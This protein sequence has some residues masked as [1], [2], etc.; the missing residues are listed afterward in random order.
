MLG[1]EGHLAVEVRRVGKVDA[2]VV[3]GGTGAPIVVLAWFSQ[4]CRF[5]PPF[6]RKLTA[7]GTVYA[8]SL[9][10]FGHTA[11]PV[12]FDTTYDLVNF[13]L[14]FVDTLPH[15][16]V[17]LVGLSFGGWLALELATKNMPGLERLVL[18][19]TLGVKLSDREDDGYRRHLQFAPRRYSC[20]PLGG[21][22]SG[23]AGFRCHDGR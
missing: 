1:A 10:G 4:I 8:P 12:D 5:N 20:A 11:R 13:C 17:T 18:I 6:L 15:G 2:E 22:G 9:P 21:P 3:I 16:P 19:D 7:C 14:D 23:T